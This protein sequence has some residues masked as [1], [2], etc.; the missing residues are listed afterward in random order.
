VRARQHADETRSIAEE[1]RREL[2]DLFDRR[3]APRLD[4][5]AILGAGDRSRQ[6]AEE[7]R[8]SLQTES[9]DLSRIAGRVESAESAFG[10]GVGLSA[11]GA[12]LSHHG[13]GGGRSGSNAW[14]AVDRVATLGIGAGGGYGGGGGR[15]LSLADFGGSTLSR[16]LG[17][18]VFGGGGAGRRNPL[19]SVVDSARQRARQIRQAGQGVLTGVGRYLRSGR[20]L[21]D[22]VRQVAVGAWSKIW[23]KATSALRTLRSA[24]TGVVNRLAA[25]VRDPQGTAWMVGRFVIELGRAE[26]NRRINQWRARFGLSAYIAG[27]AIF[28]PGRLDYFRMPSWYRRQ[29]DPKVGRGDTETLEERKEELG[30]EGTFLATIGSKITFNRTRVR[31]ADGTEWWEV[32]IE[33]EVSGGAGIGAGGSARAGKAGKGARTSADLTGAQIHKVTYRFRSKAEADRFLEQVRQRYLREAWKLLLHSGQK[34]VNLERLVPFRSIFDIAKAL[35]GDPASITESFEGRAKGKAE[36]EGGIARAKGE[37]EGKVGVDFTDGNEVVWVEVSGS[38]R[39]GV[40]MLGLTA[41]MAHK[42][43]GKVSIDPGNPTRVTGTF[44]Y[45]VTAE[46]DLTFLQKKLNPDQLTMLKRKLVETGGKGAELRFRLDASVSGAAVDA[47]RAALERGD[48][49]AA[50]RIM[51]ERGIRGTITVELWG[52]QERS[53]ELSI[54]GAA[55]GKAGGKAEGSDSTKQRLA[56]TSYQF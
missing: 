4:A 55:G 35:E 30:L 5:G 45:T 11:I 22:R 8:W 43:V 34:V 9:S 2:R 17:S 38:A 44:T 56:S 12:L 50:Q 49:D 27:T 14:G 53:G 28:D 16:I 29:P 31:A 42:L 47:V 24:L 32:E 52:V 15:G 36:A 25:A 18:P 37:L 6:R 26:I 21:A 19:A 54:E 51:R 33:Q 39:G 13:G 7:I 40:S 41:S 23:A 46:A 48:L 3:A 20:D 10:L 1:A